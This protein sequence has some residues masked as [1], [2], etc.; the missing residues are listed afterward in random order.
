MTEPLL[1]V[2][3]LVQRFSVR[4]GL[5][6]RE[7]DPCVPSMASELRPR[8]RQS[9]ASSATRLRQ[10]DHG[11][12]RPVRLI[13]PTAGEIWFDGQNVTALDRD[14]LRSLCPR[15]ADHLPGPIRLAQPGVTVGAIISEALIIHK[16]ARS[17]KDLPPA[18]GADY[19][20]PSAC[21]RSACTAIRTSSPATTPA[22]RSRPRLH[23]Q[24][25]ADRSVTSRFRRSTVDPG[26]GHQSAR[27]PA[28]EV[29]PDLPVHRP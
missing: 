18:G 27:G 3:D 8:R 9:W 20:R 6:S 10:V 5:F 23:D 26:A 21:S 1:R 2:K 22:D 11:A 13:E 17:R 16:L 19:S 25:Q 29:R 7:L 15:H 4:G 12:L 24:A 28:A 14:A